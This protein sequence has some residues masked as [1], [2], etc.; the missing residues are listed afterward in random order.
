MKYIPYYFKKQPCNTKSLGKYTLVEIHAL[1]ASGKD[2][3]EDEAVSVEEI[4]EVN[5][6]VHVSSHR[7]TA[8]EVWIQVDTQRTNLADFFTYED[9]PPSLAEEG[10]LLWR[11]WRILIDK[12]NTPAFMP[13]DMPP[14]L[15]DIALAATKGAV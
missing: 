2:A 10:A 3:W 15:M 14:R 7:P 9:A 8:D 13:K 4:C 5:D 11:G 12:T 1:L 6:I